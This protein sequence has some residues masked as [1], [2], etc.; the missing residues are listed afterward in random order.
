MTG[1]SGPSFGWNNQD[2]DRLP[3]SYW[4]SIVH[5]DVRYHLFRRRNPAAC[6]RSLWRLLAHRDNVQR[7]VDC[8]SRYPHWVVSDELWG[9]I[10][11]GRHAVS[12]VCPGC[13]DRR[14]EA[15]GIVLLWVP[16]EWDARS[17]DERG[18]DHLNVVCE[19]IGAFQ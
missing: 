11:G 5:S 15:K 16:E 4:L 19:R 13:L 9:R 1:Q 10:I 3:A 14:A 18:M 2:G 17:S 8:G 7:C 6:V 12:G